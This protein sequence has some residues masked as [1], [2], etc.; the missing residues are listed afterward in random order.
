V[1]PFEQ[2]SLD[3]IQMPESR[4]GKFKWILTAI[5]HCTSWPV[6][7]PLKEA[8]AAELAKAI[9]EHVVCPFGAPK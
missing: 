4:P 3:L 5:D 1:E 7:I 8:T 2:W 9:F 6:A